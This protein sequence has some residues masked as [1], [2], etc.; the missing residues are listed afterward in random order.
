M[1]H[2]PLLEL[3]PEL[4]EQNE[5]GDDPDDPQT[6]REATDPNS[7]SIDEA[8]AAEMEANT[9]F[10]DLAAAHTGGNN[11][12]VQRVKRFISK[13]KVNRGNIA[14]GRT[15]LVTAEDDNMRYGDD[16]SSESDTEGD[17]HDGITLVRRNKRN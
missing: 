11:G 15:R 17:Q 1:L 16:E 14:V 2:I 6:P 3:R 9:S 12:L 5:T 10:H 4:R 8:N 13:R 7:Q